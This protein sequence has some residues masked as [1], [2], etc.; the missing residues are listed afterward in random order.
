MKSKYTYRILAV[1]F[2]SICFCMTL[3][4]QIT[5][6]ILEKVLREGE[7]TEVIITVQEPESGQVLNVYAVNAEEIFFNDA[8]IPMTGNLGENTPFIISL[9]ITAK[10]PIVVLS[11]YS[12]VAEL[13]AMPEEVS[14]TPISPGQNCDGSVEEGMSTSV[15]EFTWE[16]VGSF[17]EY[18]VVFYANDCGKHP[19]TPTTPTPGTPSTVT[20]GGNTTT[21]QP[22]NTTTQGTQTTGENQT[23]DSKP[24]KYVNMDDFG[25]DVTGQDLDDSDT[26]DEGLPPLP[27]GWEWGEYGATWTGEHPPEP[28]NLPDGWEW[29]P[30][31][32]RWV[33]QGEPCTQSIIG[34]SG[35]IDVESINIDGPFHQVSVDMNEIVV[36]G[37]AFVYQVFGVAE[38][39]NGT[40]VA[41]LSDEMCSRYS[42][43]DTETG[44]LVS[45]LE[46]PQE[47][48]GCTLNYS[49]VRKTP[50]KVTRPLDN[51]P[52]GDALK[53]MIPGECISF[54]IMANDFDLIKQ[55]CQGQDDCA[56]R[57]EAV[58]R[59]GP[60]E[61]DVVYNW[62]LNGEGKLKKVCQNTIFYETPEKFKKNEKKVATIDIELA[63]GGGKIADDPIQGKAKLTMT[64]I[65]SCKCI[66]T[67]IVL[68][69]PKEKTYDDD[70]KEK[71]ADLCKPKDPEWKKD[72]PI[73]GTIVVKEV[74]CPKSLTILESAFA[75][76]DKLKLVCEAASC[77]KDDEEID[78][79]DPLKYVWDDGGAG[80]VFPFGNTGPCVLYQAPDTTI[81]VTLKAKVTDSGTQATD[82][83]KDKKG[84]SNI[85]QLLDLTEVNS[86]QV[87]KYKNITVGKVQKFKPVWTPKNVKIKKIVWE[88]D[89]GGTTGKIRKV[90][91]DPKGLSTDQAALKF[92]NNKKESKPLEVSWKVH[93]HIHGIKELKC[94]ITGE[95]PE[96]K[97]CCL[98]RD[99]EWKSSDFLKKD[100]LSITQFRLFF[101][102]EK[103]KDDGRVPNAGVAASEDKY[104]EETKIH[105][106]DA[107]NWFKH[108]SKTT[109]QTC[110]HDHKLTDPQV[111]YSGSNK[112]LGVYQK[113]INRISL[114]KKAA[115]KS[116]RKQWK[117]KVM[118]PGSDMKWVDTR[119]KTQQAYDLKGHTLA[120]KVFLHEM[121]HF[122]SMTKNWRPGQVWQAAYGNR[123]TAETP[124]GAIAV[125]PAGNLIKIEVNATGNYNGRKAQGLDC[126]QKYDITITLYKRQNNQVV[127]D[128]VININD[129]WFVNRPN[130]N[131]TNR[132][133]TQGTV[134][135]AFEIKTTSKRYR[136]MGLT[137]SE[138]DRPNDPDGDFIPNV[139][140]DRVGTNWQHKLTHTNHKRGKLKTSNG[141][142]QLPD[143]EFWA[144][145]YMF[146]RF[147]KVTP[148]NP[149]KDWANPGE[150][151]DPEYK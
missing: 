21:T 103:F 54:S 68:I 26:G 48:A 120:N 4:S 58:K 5:I 133:R 62:K 93:S 2:L 29:G 132:Q 55:V 63:N 101:D 107:I 148:G 64:F 14:I 44:E 10:S 139:E 8:T 46:C 106:T 56:E 34:T 31:Y 115:Q 23:S 142:D 124:K 121:G 17:T 95:V 91:C 128:K 140:E 149:S 110:E 33:G 87:K 112:F 52:K 86:D 98:C 104:G 92:T 88:L 94:E 75:D 130:I 28:P 74:L 145:Q 113:N 45:D 51:F 13:I 90:L 84:N 109:Y 12:I 97:D 80:G 147:R 126:V 20:P 32:P 117:G 24:P 43:V 82:D 50:I 96:C 37:E 60:I 22:T 108:W 135:G 100:T 27:P 11:E 66:N 65:D 61:H 1:S 150:Q 16:S 127:V 77:G 81:K 36:P 129:A 102:K 40:Q 49:W 7:S 42:P 85:K 73:D 25:D 134:N 72:K 6:N 111:N 116:K 3:H 131:W 39:N 119:N 70:F 122:T 76:T 78:L 125:A 71:E 138:F 114:T 18:E 38:L 47:K 35:I 143:Q 144:D 118:F 136:Y 19:G 79:N 15:M 83:P 151:S 146:D 67:E 123:T 9:P 141:L 105:G 41:V 59:I 69:Q 89:L 137:L 99:D 57:E 30:T 53:E